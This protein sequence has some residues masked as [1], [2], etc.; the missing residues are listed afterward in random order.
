MTLYNTTI[1]TLTTK[2]L[3]E[4]VLSNPVMAGGFVE[5]ASTANG[6]AWAMFAA[7]AG[8]APDDPILALEAA[9]ELQ[10]LLLEAT[11]AHLDKQAAILEVRRL[12][13]EL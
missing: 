5:Y 8:K 2:F 13:G 9:L 6:V 7:R 3:T 1:A 11:V 4:E 12:T 10:H